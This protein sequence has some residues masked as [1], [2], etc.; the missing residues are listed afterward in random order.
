[1]LYR[2]AKPNTAAAITFA[3]FCVHS[4]RAATGLQMARKRSTA[5]AIVK[6]VDPVCAVIIIKRIFFIKF[7]KSYE[8]E[9]MP[10]YESDGPQPWSSEGVEIVRIN[11]SHLQ[12]L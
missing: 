3:L 9:S 4:E 2:M 12:N 10:T 11:V 8:I 1:M 7:K 6:Y 5:K